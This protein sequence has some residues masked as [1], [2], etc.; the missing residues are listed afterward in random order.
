MNAA[1][2]L[3]ERKLH[4]EGMSMIAASWV[5]CRVVRDDPSFGDRAKGTFDLL[6]SLPQSSIELVL[7]RCGTACSP[8]VCFCGVRMKESA[9]YA[10]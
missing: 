8:Q 2:T 3:K 10:R 7:R 9:A 6:A 5:A 1:S 4:Q